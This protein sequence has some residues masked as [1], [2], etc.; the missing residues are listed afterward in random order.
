MTFKPESELMDKSINST[1][2]RECNPNQKPIPDSGIEIISIPK[3]GIIPNF[4]RT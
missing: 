1:H 3:T 4:I 2:T